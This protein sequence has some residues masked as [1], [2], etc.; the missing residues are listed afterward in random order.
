MKKLIITQLFFIWLV[1]PTLAEDLKLN[2]NDVSELPIHTYKSKQSKANM[3][4]I[5]GGKGMKNTKGKSKNHPKSKISV[6]TQL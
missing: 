2:F 3:I 5:I 4:A 6:K 1:S